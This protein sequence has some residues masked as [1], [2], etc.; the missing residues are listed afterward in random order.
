VA[1]DAKPVFKGPFWRG[2]PYVD[3]VRR[4]ESDQPWLWLAA[5]WRDMKRAPGIS[6]FFGLMLAGLSAFFT[7]GLYL[8]DQT[9]AIAPALGGFLIVGPI[10]SVGM[11]ALSREIEAGRRPTFFD[12]LFSWRRNPLNIFGGGVALAL[13]FLIWMRGA[14]L[15]FAVLF[16]YKGGTI[17]GLVN[18]TLFTVEGWTFLVVGTAVGA[19][20]AF[21][22]FV[23]SSVSLQIMLDRR[24]DVFQGAMASLVCVAGNFRTMMIW[25]A[26]IV[27]LTAAG[28]ATGFLGFI[29][30]L[31]LVGH[32][33]W[34]AYRALLGR[35]DTAA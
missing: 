26:L 17:Q 18:A 22:A 29:V 9:W 10:L 7:L 21:V 20:F 6:L 16:P 15:I 30:I 1:S 25:A 24:V 19:F 4:L 31:P 27:G 33:S 23:F 8:L 28:F 13:Y 12:I 3:E 14:A 5:G 11:Y 34:H 2:F 35:P 32:A